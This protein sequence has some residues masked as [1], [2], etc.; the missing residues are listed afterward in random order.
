MHDE[1]R[2][3]AWAVGGARRLSMA[4]FGA[5]FMRHWAG[6]ERALVKSEC[7][8]TYLEPATRSWQAYQR[9]DFAAVPGLLSA[10][11]D[12]DQ[13]I[14]DAAV[15]N[16]TPFVRVRAVRPPL[17]EYLMFEMWN[18]VVR[19]ERGETIEVAVIPADDLRPLPN[20]SYFDFLLFDDRAAL[21]HD[22]GLDGLQVGGWV[23]TSPMSLR[24]LAETADFVR[25]NAIPLEAFLERHGLTF[26]P[27]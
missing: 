2:P 23:T 24:R 15:K 7:W 19:A 10:E 16:D 6:V 4:Q 3:P 5:E 20:H 1:I 25:R 18:Y 22:Y 9:G 27:R 17:T 11:A 13:P 8:Q 21:V 14:Y 26:P 12:T